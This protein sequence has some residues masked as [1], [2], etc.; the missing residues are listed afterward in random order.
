MPYCLHII[1]VVK[2]IYQE[3]FNTIM[4]GLLLYGA[5]KVEVPGLPYRNADPELRT[6]LLLCENAFINWHM[7]N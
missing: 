5:S 6:L 7:Q 1:I 2:P 4:V 3:F